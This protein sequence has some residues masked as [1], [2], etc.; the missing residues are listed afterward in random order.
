MSTISTSQSTIGQMLL[1][2]RGGTTV[3]YYLQDDFTPDDAAP[4]TSPRNADGI[5]Q[6]NATDTAGTLL[7]IASSKL[8][9]SGRTAGGDPRLVSSSSFARATGLCAYI[10]QYKNTVNRGHW[11]WADNNTVANQYP[12]LGIGDIGSFGDTYPPGTSVSF[13][14]NTLYDVRAILFSSGGFVVAKGGDYTNWTILWVDKTVSSTP[15]Y[16]GFWPR[17][18]NFGFECDAAGVCQLPSPFVTDTGLATYYDATPSANDT[19]TSEANATQYFKWTVTAAETL[20]IRFRRVDD[21]NCYRLECDQAA[22][23]IKLLK[24]DTAV[25]TELDAG[26]TQTWTAST[27]YRIAIR[28]EGTNI[29]TW[30]GATA[31]HDVSA[32]SFNQTETGAKVS[33][34]AAAAGWEIWP[35]ELGGAA[36][37]I[38]SNI[39]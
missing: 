21:D 17:Y 38:L 2:R 24:R 33:G 26:Q 13:A 36:A 5:G 32:Q 27:T 7:D 25:D 34:F 15:M 14:N 39:G 37:T 16:V 9:A 28:H 19:A 30:V 29:K 35:W 31:K 10:N 8:I 12:D 1:M 23:T 18:T 22:G 11:G 6:W 20:I 3:E 4:L